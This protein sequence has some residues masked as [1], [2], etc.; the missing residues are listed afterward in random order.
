MGIGFRIVLYGLGSAAVGVT[1]S[2]NRIYGTSQHFC[3][4]FIDGFF[5][6]VFWFHRVLRQRIPVFL[7]FGNG[8]LQL[9]YGSGN[10]R[11]L[12][13]VCVRFCSEFS[14]LRKI[15]RNLLLLTQHLRKI[16]QDPPRQ[17]NIRYQDFHI[18]RFCKCFYN[19]QKRMGGQHGSFIRKGV[20]DFCF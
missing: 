16:S 13:D 11:K 9:R 15:I 7:K 5:R 1:F 4:F 3:I 8:F 17:R 14:Q 2:Q 12:D 20:I 10:I 6:C 19:R 18:G